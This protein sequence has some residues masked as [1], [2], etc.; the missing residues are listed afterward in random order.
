MRLRDLFDTQSAQHIFPIAVATA[1]TDNESPIFRAPFN[2]KVTAVRFIPET[3]VVGGAT[4]FATVAVRNK[5]AAGTGTTVVASKAFDTATTDDVAAFDE[6]AITLSATAANLL[7][8]EGEVLAANVTKDGTG[9]SIDGI[10]IVEY[11]P[12]GI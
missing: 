8:A 3:A 12:R 6:D 5:G 7:V 10:L 4:N 11:I 2:L 1:G 9:E